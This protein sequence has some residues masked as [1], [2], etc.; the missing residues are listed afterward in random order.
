MQCNNDRNG[1]HMNNNNSADFFQ[2]SIDFLNISINNGVG[3]SKDPI[4]S[5]NWTASF[6]QLAPLLE[7]DD[8]DFQ[9]DTLLDFA[10]IQ[11]NLR[12]KRTAQYGQTLHLNDEI[13]KRNTLVV[14]QTGAG[15]TQR[16]MLPFVCSQIRNPKSSIVYIASKGNEYELV[17]KMAAHYRPGTTVKV[18]NF[19]NASRSNI[20]WNPFETSKLVMQNREGTAL[21]DALNFCES[22]EGHEKDVRFWNE[23]ASRFIAALR[24]VLEDT[25]GRA[26][27]GVIHELSERPRLELLNFFKDKGSVKFVSGVCEYLLSENRGQNAETV[28]ATAQ[29]YLKL[30]C[31]TDLKAVTSCESFSFVDLFE[32]PEILV[33][34]VPQHCGYK[35]RPILNLF[36]ASLF[37]DVSLYVQG[38]PDAALPR[39]LS[40]YLDDF[41]ACLG[42]IP[43]I[44]QFLNTSRSRNVRVTAS[45][46]EMWQLSQFYPEAETSSI[47]N[48]FCT[49]IFTSDISMMD[50]CYASSLSG[51]TT[52]DFVRRQGTKKR[53][54]TQGNVHER[55]RVAFESWEPMERSL[56]TSSDIKNP[57]QHFAFGPASTFFITGY[58]PFQAWTCPAYDQPELGVLIRLAQRDCKATVDNNIKKAGEDEYHKCMASLC[59]SSDLETDKMSLDE[60]REVLDWS[61]TSGTARKWWQTFEKENAEKPELIRKLMEELVNRK[62]TI[63]EFFLCYVYADIVN[64]QGCLYY[65]DYSR[66]KKEEEKQ[67]KRKEDTPDNIEQSP[68]EDLLESNSKSPKSTKQKRA[69]QKSRHKTE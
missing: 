66:I 27:P 7:V 37:R 47:L 26:L 49:K 46:Q 4:Y 54:S 5:S 52:V 33:L 40:I 50:A 25:M 3:R 67:K 56:L 20:G 21:E 18:L 69:K 45:L 12:G 42:R 10:P 23:N 57:P 51:T 62:A 29:G 53:H 65:L 17:R 30:F 64:I 14:G 31:D 36:F 61:N 9:G 55:K 6:D 24:L 35:F 68:F 63:A 58:P 44:S 1:N 32:R 28:M 15:K 11:T 16:F 48:A 59:I 38:R 22:F 2:N 39:P 19:T 34:E 60:L 8:E 41:A 43:G 13:V